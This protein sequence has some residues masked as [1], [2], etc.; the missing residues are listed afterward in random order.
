M[1]TETGPLSTIRAKVLVLLQL[2]LHLLE[3][4]HH[5]LAMGEVVGDRM[6]ERDDLASE[7]TCYL[8]D[9]SFV[10]RLHEGAVGAGHYFRLGD[11]AEG[12][13]VVHLLGNG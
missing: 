6:V 7:A 5:E 12:P 11:H 9:T 2:G 3:V 10:R 13:V 8:P 1:T 4:V